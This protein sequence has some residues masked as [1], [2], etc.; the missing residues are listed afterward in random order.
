M[1]GE[2]PFANYISRARTAL[3][4]AVEEAQALN[5]NYIGT[6]HL[7]LGLIREDGGVGLRVLE[8]LAVTA[9]QVRDLTMRK[10]RPA[11][12]ETGGLLS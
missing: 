10:L 2:D 5:H 8:S 7:L 12:N 9:E 3:H 4:L 6:E 11:E 1:H